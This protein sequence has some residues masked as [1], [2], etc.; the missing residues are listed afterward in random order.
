MNI[1]L[2]KMLINEIPSLSQ[3]KETQHIRSVIRSQSPANSAVCVMHES[4]S[5]THL[6]EFELLCFTKYTFKGENYPLRNKFKNH[7][8]TVLLAQVQNLSWG[9]LSKLNLKLLIFQA[10][11]LQLIGF[12]MMNSHRT[13]KNIPLS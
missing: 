12:K 6:P 1:L 13:V 11:L 8:N 7:L 4:G 10:D 5:P 2:N 9:I 3:K